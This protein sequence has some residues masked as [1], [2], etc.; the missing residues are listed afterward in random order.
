M[1]HLIAI[2]T[3]AT[4]LAVNAVAG[5]NK[6]SNETLDILKGVTVEAVGAY[7]QASFVSGAAEKGAGVALAIPLNKQSSVSLTG[8]LLAFEN[9]KAN[10]ENDGW[11]GDTI[12]E[13]AVGARSVLLKSENRVLRLEGEG[14]LDRS[15]QL[16]DFGFHVGVYAVWQPAKW[17]SVRLGREIRAW[18]DNKHD[19]L[20]TLSGGFTF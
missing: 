3:M 20:T 1:K 11:E 19:H 5:D 4:A 13:I 17:A 7:R 18:L 16:D 9:D 10:T 8:R 6:V 15:Q 14:G 12:D 2:L